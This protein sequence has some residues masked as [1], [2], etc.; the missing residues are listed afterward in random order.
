[1]PHRHLKDRILMSRS[2]ALVAVAA[3]QLLVTACASPSR[4]AAVPSALTAQAQT[5]IP[6]A[7][8]FPDRNDP[9]LVKE[10]IA[11]YQKERAWLASTGHTGPLPPVAF[12]TISGGG[13]DGAFGAGLLTGWTESGTRPTF[14]LVTGISTGALIAPF[15]F[16]GSKYDPILADTYLHV[17]DQDIFKKRNFTAVLFSDAIADTAPLA[18][19]VTK[20]VTRELLD[21][22]AAEYA[23]GRLLL[24]GTTNLDSREPV[25]WNM[26]AIASSK[27]PEALTL[28]R[29]IIVA[30]ASIPGAFPPVMI[31]VTVDGV[32]YQEMHVDGG[33]TRQVFMYPQTFRLAEQSA[34][35]GADRQR[36]VYIIRNSRLDPDW[37]SVDRRLLSIVNRAVSSLIQTQGLGDLYRMYLTTTRDHVDY[38]LAYIPSDFTVPKTSQFDVTYMRPLFERGRQMAAG[39]YPWAKYPP[40]YDPA[41][42]AKVAP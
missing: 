18:K 2:L 1:M 33:A 12:L 31:D 27:D 29:K 13:G 22:I 36:A 30:S 6:N 3:L 34:A 19:L 41:E 16:L 40:G 42:P 20:Y 8:F 5:S 11:S 21:A 15:A 23:K 32:H 25:Y 4:L 9:A 14:K 35:M 38:N 17:T 39:G 37:A 10:A 24:V 28:F 7:R 26:G